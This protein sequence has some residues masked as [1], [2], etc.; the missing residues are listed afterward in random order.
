MVIIVG[1][2][3]AAAMPRLASSQFNARADATARRLVADLQLAQTRARIMSKPQT[4][5]FD[6]LLGTYTINGMTDPD[7][8]GSAYVVKLGDP[9]YQAALADVQ[10]GVDPPVIGFDQYGMPVPAAGGYVLIEAGKRQR[11]ITVEANTG[12]VS[13]Q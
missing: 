7:R 6:K 1:V 13:F 2:I 8:P 10:F 3:S 9:P 4:V 12:R 11:T 5:T